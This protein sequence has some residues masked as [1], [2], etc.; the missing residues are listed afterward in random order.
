MKIFQAVQKN[1]GVLGF[2]PNQH[3]NNHWRQLNLRQI[4]GVVKCSVDSIST[5]VY[6]FTQAERTEEYMDSVFSLTVDVGITVSYISIIFKNDSLFKM[7]ESAEEEANLSM[8]S[9]FV[10]SCIWNSLKGNP[11]FP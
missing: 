6:V 1:L 4:C 5:A 2:A 3:Q 11:H 9:N 7:I 8:Y 10:S